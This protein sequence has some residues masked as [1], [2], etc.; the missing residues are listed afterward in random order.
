[1]KALVLA[2]GKG[3]RIRMLSAYCPKGMLKIMGKRLIEY[4]LDNALTVGVTGIVAVI[5]ETAKGIREYYGDTY[6]GVPIRYARQDNPLGLVNAIEKGAPLL[7]GDDFILL[8]SDEVLL[9]ADHVGMAAAFRTRSVGVVVGVMEGASPVMI[10]KN[11]DVIANA[12]RRVVRLVE[13]P[14]LPQGTLL[15]LGNCMFKNRILD[16]LPMVPP[17]PIR[18]QRDMTDLIQCAI[19]SGERV[20]HYPL[21]TEYA[22][23]NT[24]EDYEIARSLL[25]RQQQFSEV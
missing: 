6:R 7:D 20:E 18:G 8:L 9:G 16:Y 2:A 5:N 25:E 11:Y 4:N 1:M 19:D 13:K 24:P 12:G 15:G 10:G 3:T 17:N 21:C 23:V 22:N 14:I